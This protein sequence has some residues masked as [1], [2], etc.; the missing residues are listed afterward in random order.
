M[1][2]SRSHTLP[3]TR[4]TRRRWIYRLPRCFPPLRYTRTRT[5]HQQ[6]CF[7]PLRYTTRDHMYHQQV[8]FPPPRNTR[9]SIIYRHRRRSRPQQFYRT[10]RRAWVR[11]R[12]R[13]PPRARRWRLQNA[14]STRVTWK[15]M[16]SSVGAASRPSAYGREAQQDVGQAQRRARARRRW[17]PRT[18]SASGEPIVEWDK[19]LRLRPD[20]LFLSY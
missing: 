15:P 5:Y 19:N 9:S 18:S 16:E 8:C 3:S 17:H 6:I 12:D 20:L 13:P 1:I 7:P 2:R 10:N 4:C 14:S 11:P